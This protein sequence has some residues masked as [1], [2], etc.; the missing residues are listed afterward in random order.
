MRTLDQIINELPE[1]RRA[2]VMARTQTLVE[3]E[4]ALRQ[5]RQAHDLTQQAMANALGLD[6]GAISKI[7][8]RGDMLISTLR[9]YVEAMGGS[10]K[11]VVEFEDG[12][13]ELAAIGETL[14]TSVKNAPK[15]A[16]RLK[17]ARVDG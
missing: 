14:S 17:R 11:L 15:P 1:E 16:R 5:L 13:V 7:E 6:Q 4:K 8:N 9:S 2:K 3:E 12:A 10:L